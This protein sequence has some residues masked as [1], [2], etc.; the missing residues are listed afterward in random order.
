MYS[1]ISNTLRDQVS[2]MFVATLFYDPLKC[3]LKERPHVCRWNC[4]LL[5]PGT[6]MSAAFT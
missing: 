1:F 4:T 6:K 2:V 3:L 5:T